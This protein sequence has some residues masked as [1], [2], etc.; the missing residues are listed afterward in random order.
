M[1]VNLGSHC[2]CSGRRSSLLFLL[3]VR[4]G[5]WSGQQEA[6]AIS[7]G[8]RPERL[9]LGVHIEHVSDLSGIIKQ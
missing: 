4:L 7:L 8:I 2:C 9:V 6:S 5:Y 1:L 3:L